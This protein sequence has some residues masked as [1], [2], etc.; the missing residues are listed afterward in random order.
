M[1]VIHS[2]LS[3]LFSWCC[4]LYQ[5]IV[6]SKTSCHG[7][8]QMV[9][10]SQRKKL[11]S[12]TSSRLSGTLHPFKSEVYA[13]LPSYSSSHWDFRSVFTWCVCN[14]PL[15]C[16]D[17]VIVVWRWKTPTRAQPVLLLVVHHLLPETTPSGTAA[18]I[19]Q[20]SFFFSFFL[21]V[22]LPQRS[23]QHQMSKNINR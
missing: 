11:L 16:L 23:V 15:M 19:S 13:F 5:T 22:Y 10:T 7:L 8:V 9:Y 20:S 1:S 6:A 14:S 12:A 17:L 3:D 2:S 21:T 4:S 18:V